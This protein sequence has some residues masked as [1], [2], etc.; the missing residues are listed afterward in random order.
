MAS[1]P[2]D[3]AGRP[4]ADRAAGA[5]LDG[6]ERDLDVPVGQF[7]VQ[8]AADL[9]DLDAEPVGDQVNRCLP[10]HLDEAGCLQHRFEVQRTAEAHAVHHHV[11]DRIVVVERDLGGRDAADVLRLGASSAARADR[12]RSRGRCPTRRTTR[13]RTVAAA[14]SWS[15]QSGGEVRRRIHQAG[16]RRRHDVDAGLEQLAGSP[17]PRRASRSGPLAA[18]TTQ[19]GCQRDQRVGVVGGGQPHRLTAGQFAGVLPTL[20]GECTHTPTSS[21]SGRR[22]MASMAI[23]PTPPVDHTTTR[24]DLPSV[25]PCSSVD[26]LGLLMGRRRCLQVSPGHLGVDVAAQRVQR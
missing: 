24:M 23:D 22:R 3:H 11:G 17:A 14:S 19:S 4:G 26:H 6:A 1:R 8:G 21:R 13:R 12:R 7:A 16:R 10:G 5:G 2:F 20:S 18:Y 25:S 9:L 15:R